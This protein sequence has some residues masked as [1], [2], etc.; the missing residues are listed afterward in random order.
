[1]S[2]EFGDSSLEYHIQRGA[3]PEDW[4]THWAQVFGDPGWELG[5]F[6]SITRRSVVGTSSRKAS[7]RQWPVC[8]FGA[9]VLPLRPRPRATI[10]H[11]G[12]FLYRRWCRNV[13]DNGKEADSP[14]LPFSFG[15][16]F[17]SNVNKRMCLS[18]FL[19]MSNAYG[20]KMI[21]PKS[22]VSYCVAAGEI[23]RYLLSRPV[24]DLL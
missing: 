22:L 20:I 7:R 15:D 11:G 1:M 5:S 9:A 3:R 4:L 12:R 8:A 16:A 6:L 14:N 2:E 17:N 10:W 21:F 24:F 18:I 13:T 19:P 23:K